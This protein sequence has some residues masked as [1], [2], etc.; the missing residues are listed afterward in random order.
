MDLELDPASTTPP[1]EQLRV[2]LL[3][4]MQRGALPAGC[5]RDRSR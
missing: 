3:E 2:Q 5:H 4:R 1:Y